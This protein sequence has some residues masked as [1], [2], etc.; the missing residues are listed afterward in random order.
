VSECVSVRG[1]GVVFW[2]GLGGAG[3][4]SN[5]FYKFEGTKQKQHWKSGIEP[6][7]RPHTRYRP[8]LSVWDIY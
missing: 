6:I 5:V 3:L 1:V 4:Y 8:F 2:T 7:L